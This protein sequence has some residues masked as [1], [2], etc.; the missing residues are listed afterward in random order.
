MVYI[1]PMGTSCKYYNISINMQFLSIQIIGVK[2]RDI[3]FIMSA[4]DYFK[5]QLL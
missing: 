4:L 2:Y 3:S 1:G 5:S